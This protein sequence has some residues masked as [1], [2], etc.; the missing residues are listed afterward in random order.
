M[1]LKSGRN[2]V[3]L[4]LPGT[5]AGGGDNSLIVGLTA[6]GGEVDFPG[7]A[8][9]APGDPFPGGFQRFL[10]LLAGGVKTGGLP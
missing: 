10:G 8:T 1:V 6:A 9:Q 7:F 3:L 2:D 4:T 5:E